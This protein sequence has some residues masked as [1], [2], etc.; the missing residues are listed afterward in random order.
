MPILT[1]ILAEA[2]YPEDLIWS[3]FFN[4]FIQVYVINQV[5]T[6]CK[7]IDVHNLLEIDKSNTV[8]PNG[9]GTVGRTCREDPL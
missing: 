9:V 8:K 7:T 5:S 3:Q 6:W 4:H 2:I 1:Y